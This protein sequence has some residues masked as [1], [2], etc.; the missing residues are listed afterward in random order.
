[1]T[2][3]ELQNFLNTKAHGNNIIVENLSDIDRGMFEFLAT[4]EVGECFD[5]NGRNIYIVNCPVCGN[6]TY[7][8]FNICLECFWEYDGV[9]TGYSSPNK[10]TVE[11]Y[12][13]HYH[14]MEDISK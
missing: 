13:M 4:H 1:M 8:D 12:R 2:N 7:D 3:I 5:Y 9:T 11:E 10:T 6:K 14:M